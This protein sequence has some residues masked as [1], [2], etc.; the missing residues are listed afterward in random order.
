MLL[1]AY[2][3]VLGTSLPVM[4]VMTM[5][6]FGRVVSLHPY[7]RTRKAVESSEDC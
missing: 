2:S 6:V 4:T 7:A 5:V 1:N 3:A